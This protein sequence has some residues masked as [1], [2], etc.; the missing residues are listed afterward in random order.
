MKLLKVKDLQ[1]TV[2]EK[3]LTFTHKEIEI[4]LDRKMGTSD[5]R[6]VYNYLKLKNPTH[7]K[8]VHTIG[9][10]GYVI[11]DNVVTIASK[12]HKFENA[13][14]IDP[15]LKKNR[16]QIIRNKVIKFIINNI[17]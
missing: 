13:F 16:H 6:I 1:V 4:T 14:E 17:E 9:N 7:T 3:T 15:E 5:Y 10:F 2:N 8:G 12:N 11:N